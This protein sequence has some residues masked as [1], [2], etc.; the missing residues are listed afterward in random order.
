MLAKLFWFLVMVLA[1]LGL[2]K[3]TEPVKRF[4]GDWDWAEKYLSNGGTYTAIK[5]MGLALIIVA[6]LYITD[7]WQNIIPGFVR[8]PV[9]S[10]EF[11][12]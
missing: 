8:P 5:L 9:T 6:M 2:L 10:S 12:P 1:G 11:A 3:Y 7:T 4:T